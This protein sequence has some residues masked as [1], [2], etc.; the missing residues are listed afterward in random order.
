M[1]PKF[2]DLIA[3]TFN[4]MGARMVQANAEGVMAEFQRRQRL[5][6]AGQPAGKSVKSKKH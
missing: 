6:A 2:Q 3:P 5:Q 4:V 1:K